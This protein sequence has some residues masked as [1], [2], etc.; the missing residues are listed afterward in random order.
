[1]H[2]LGEEEKIDMEPFVEAKME[3]SRER[4]IVDWDLKKAKNHLAEV[5]F[6]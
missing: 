5:L 1:M 6:N 4:I 2:L 3:K